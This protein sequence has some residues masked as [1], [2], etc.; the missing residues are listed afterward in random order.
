M[1]IRDGGVIADGYDDELDD[2]RAI[3]SN[4]DQYLL[5]LE[6]REKER[7]GISTLKLGRRLL[8]SSGWH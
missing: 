6:A 1:L 2:L 4:A 8:S 3:A 5:D 7:T